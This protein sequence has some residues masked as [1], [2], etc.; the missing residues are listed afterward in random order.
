LQVPSLPTTAH[1]LQVPEQAVMQHLPCAQIFELH[2]A[3]APQLAPIGFGPQ[4]PMTQ[5]LGVTQSASVAHVVRHV[6]P[7]VAHWKGAQS[8]V[9]APVQPPALSQVAVVM[10]MWPT[11]PSCAQVTPAVPLKRAHWPVPSQTPVVPQVSAVWVGQRSPGS[12]PWNAGR[13]VPSLPG[14][15]HVKHAWSHAVLQQTPSTHWA[16]PHSDPA[17]QLSPSCL[18]GLSELPVSNVIGTSFGPP[19]VMYCW[20]PPPQPT[21]AAS[22][23][24][25]TA[26]AAAQSGRP[27][28]W[29]SKATAIDKPFA[30]GISKHACRF[31]GLFVTRTGAQRA[32]HILRLELSRNPLI[33]ALSSRARGDYA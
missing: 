8:C 26:Q 18:S 20:P 16:E 10:R 31:R 22:N 12:V 23:T 1:D 27:N 21:A 25:K 4:L 33:N 32:S 11:Q 14:F 7:S 28:V 29:R 15:W 6:L 3:S 5:L 19:S 9:D 13:Q 24:A 30:R 17:V 2:S